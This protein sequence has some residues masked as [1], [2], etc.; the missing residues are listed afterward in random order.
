MVG[1]MVNGRVQ[2]E[3]R[4]QK[5]AKGKGVGAECGEGGE[6][7]DKYGPLNPIPSD[8]ANKALT[9]IEKSVCMS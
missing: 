3:E 1:S 2:F 6:E 5:L 7:V 4:Y 8:A 9:E